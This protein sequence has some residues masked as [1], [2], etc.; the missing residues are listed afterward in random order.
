MLKLMVVLV[1]R[2]DMSPAEFRAYFRDIHGPMGEAL[3]GLR[4]YVQNYRT[5]DPNR[6]PPPWDGIA[7][8]WFDD[9]EALQAAFASEAGGRATRDLP[10]FA[11]VEATTLS[12]MD[13]VELI[14][15]AEEP[16]A[17]LS[18]TPGT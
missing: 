9:Y 7:E 8:L 13:E 12:I 15:G 11:D 5:D 18:E 2:R 17:P 6:E 14:T 1:R 3:P 16:A 4:R 10:E